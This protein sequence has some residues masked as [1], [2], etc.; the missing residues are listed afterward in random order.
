MAA[1]LGVGDTA[2]LAAAPVAGAA[3]GLATGFAAGVEI[4]FS[5]GF[6]ASVAAGLAAG[7][8]T[9]LAGDGADALTATDRLGDGATVL[10][11]TA[12]GAG[13]EDG[14]LGGWADALGAEPLAT[15]VAVTGFAACTAF[16]AFSAGAVFAAAPGFTGVAGAAGAAFKAGR[17][18]V[19]AEEGARL[20][21]G[22]GDFAPALGFDAT[23][24][25]G[26]AVAA[27]FFTACLLGFCSGLLAATAEDTGAGAAPGTVAGGVIPALAGKIPSPC[28]SE[29]N[30][31]G[32]TGRSEL[33]APHYVRHCSSPCTRMSRGKS[34]PMNTILLTRASPGAQRG[35]RSLPMSWCTPW[36]MTLRS[37]PCMFNTPL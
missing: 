33:E 35:P 32:G 19:G 16:A 25:G 34:I 3:V 22:P 13:F 27:V 30:S 36:K 26:E 24:W 23:G 2:G 11:A 14:F 7:F 9:G 10:P 5:A 4:G 17:G 20:D 15:G 8:T 18:D 6:A 21:T 31:M 37:V 12:T 29:T 28:N 1:A